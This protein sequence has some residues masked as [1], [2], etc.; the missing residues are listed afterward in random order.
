MSVATPPRPAPDAEAEDRVLARFLSR[1]GLVSE[2][3]LREC[4]EA[5]ER[6]EQA[7]R[8][9]PRLGKLLC[10]LGVL[11][12]KS[13][14]ESVAASHSESAAAPAAPEGEP[15]GEY[16]KVE[17]VGRG[18]FGEVW[19]AWDTALAR[20]VALKLLHH[21][22][23][24]ELRRFTREA[25]TAA[26]L[27]HPNIAAVYQVGAHDGKQFIAMQFIDG[28]T[29]HA[30]R[31]KDRREIARLLRDAARAVAF[32]HRQGIVHRDL[33]PANIMVSFD[34][35]PGGRSA[36]DGDRD[37]RVF[38]MDFG[39]ARRTDA[40]SGVTVS[41]QMV[42]TPQYMSPEQARGERADARSDV[43]GLGATLY[44]LLEGCAPF[45][46]GTILET[47]VKVTEEEPKAP[48]G[49]LGTIAMKC[50]EKDPARRYATADALADDLDR[51]LEGEPITARP[52]ST[53]YR[54]RKRA[55][56][57]K[58]ILIPTLA[59]V[60][61]AAIAA[62]VVPR[63]LE[64]SRRRAE[65]EFYRPLEGRLDVLRMKFYQPDLRLEGE[66]PVYEKLVADIGAQM[67]KTGECAAGH[68][69]IG[70]CR[71]MLADARGADAAYDRALELDPSHAR[72]LVAKGRLEIEFA[73]VRR[74]S[75]RVAQRLEAKAL[76][77]PAIERVRRGL[78][79]GGA[80][81]DG[82]LAEAYVAVIEQRAF[83]A[84]AMR[85]RWRTE[86]F[87]E[88]FELVAGMAQPEA[89]G[90][91]D[92]ASRVA[93]AIPSLPAA[94]FWRGVARANLD[95]DAVTDFDRTLRINPR[96]VHAYVNR[97]RALFRR[98]DFDAALRDFERAVEIEPSL[99]DAH[100][101]V[102]LLRARTGD[103][104][105]AMA[106]YEEALRLDPRNADVLYMMGNLRRD[107]GEADAA[108]ALYGR[109][110][111]LLPSM[112]EALVNRGQVRYARGDKDG[113]FA[114]WTLATERNP[115]L[116]QGF[117]NRGRVY[118]ERG[119]L[120]RARADFDRAVELAPRDASMWVARGTCRERQDDLDGA[121]ADLDEAVRLDPRS[122]EAYANRA[123]V[124][125]RKRD[126]GRT[127]EDLRRTLDLA[128]ANWPSRAKVEQQLRQLDRR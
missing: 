99:S 27:V 40:P 108:I 17:L 61:F 9:V 47:L 122:Y 11:T 104:A 21:Q 64:E 116:A 94:W 44:E 113:A 74:F 26:S 80:G 128:P 46:G 16:V 51:Y 95:E 71:E 1:H 102:G 56:K 110:L 125:G 106:C 32:A 81:M 120:D 90:V 14:D 87:V 57:R 35:A 38:V 2:E 66:Y 63:W 119:D 111:Q 72:T 107:M 92:A 58:W 70:R 62:L 103:R 117:V 45:A 126:F 19:K 12:P 96:Y 73:L 84:E 29:L 7:G 6:A 5:Q 8:T 39:L 124:H 89:K 55:A 112:A 98:G 83:D 91:V 50:L 42:G 67:R 31:R 85:V 41:G 10:E 28:E 68:Y 76:A 121:L 34:S 49:E 88:E 24:D 105:A 13:L 20:W 33:K 52:A 36:Q 43:W 18:G 23:L 86:P 97:G 75:M 79:L 127:C 48:P 59:A 101:N 65:A 3:R 82:D 115:K 30:V 109:A 69:L 78:A 118:R 123:Q 93:A 54:L 15:F 114:D 100:A 60:V 4:R 22:D 25:Q 77:G 53:I 37:G